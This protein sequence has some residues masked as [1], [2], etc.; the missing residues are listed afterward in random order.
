MTRLIDGN[1][2]KEHVVIMENYFSNVGLFKELGRDG[3]YCTSTLRIDH[4]DILQILKN[5]KEF[6]H[7]SLGTLI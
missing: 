3:T 1:N 5:T 2:E 7:S 4:I 6:N